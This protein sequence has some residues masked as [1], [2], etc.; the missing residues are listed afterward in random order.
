MKTIET[1]VIVVGAGLIGLSVAAG[2][3]LNGFRT[4]VLDR[5]A[6]GS[7]ESRAA[8]VHA[9]SL[10]VLERLGVM[11]RLVARRIP[12]RFDDA[13]KHDAYAWTVSQSDAEA[14]LRS[15]LT[16]IGSRVQWERDVRDVAQTGTFVVATLTDG[17]QVRGR[18]LVAAQ[19]TYATR[20]RIA[21]ASD[22]DSQQP[23][24]MTGVRDGAPSRVLLA[25]DEAHDFA[26]RGVNTGIFE[27][28]AL[29]DALTRALRTCD[30]RPLARIVR[31]TIPATRSA[32][33]LPT[34]RSLARQSCSAALS[35]YPAR[36]G[37]VRLQSK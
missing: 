9:R 10:E 4:T 18:Y 34:R 27:G 20:G 5:R 22:R 3:A 2:T 6:V 12:L 37:G 25:D 14:A 30:H 7:N 29:A 26:D 16:E 21:A 17:S 28:V 31:S 13:P 15:R 36:D 19:D 23:F 32:Y 8:V 1:D 24:T 33:A 35:S 11:E